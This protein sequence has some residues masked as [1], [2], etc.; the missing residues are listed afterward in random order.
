MPYGHVMD[1]RGPTREGGHC[2]L[3]EDFRELTSVDDTLVIKT[4]SILDGRGKTLCNSR[5][6]GEIL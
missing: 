5:V 2:E 6:L 4:S 3:P 1:F